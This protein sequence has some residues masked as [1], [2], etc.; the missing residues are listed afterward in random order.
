MGSRGAGSGRKSA[1]VS[2]ITSTNANTN[3][4]TSENMIDNVNGWK[5]TGIQNSVDKLETALN[6]A[7]STARVAKVYSELK[8]QDEIITQEIQRLHDGTADVKG[9]ENA[10]LTQRRRVRQM[11]RNIGNRR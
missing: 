11:M 5:Y 6:N 7:R 4:S 2:P 10:L 9:N 8:K 1:I 3:A